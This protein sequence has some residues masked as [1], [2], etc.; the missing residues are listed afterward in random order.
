M[1]K[2]YWRLVFV[3]TAYVYNGF[4]GYDERNGVR[5][6]ALTYAGL[7]FFFPFEQVTI[8]PDWT[9]RELDHDKSTPDGEGE[10]ELVYKTFVVN[11]R[12]VAE[13][14]LMTQVPVRNRDKGLIEIQGKP[15]GRM[16][17][18]TSGSDL[19]GQTLTAEVQEK[20]A[21]KAEREQAAKLSLD[22]K[23]QLIQEYFQSKRERMAGGK[24]RIFPHGI[25]KV[26]MDELQVEDIDDVSRH[27]KV[28]GGLDPATI[29]ALVEAIYKGQ[30]INGARLQE[31][32]ETVRKAGKAQLTRGKGRNTGMAE[33]REAY[34][35]AI[36][37]GKTPEEARELAEAARG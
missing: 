24:G 23:K 21:T 29:T 15:T 37:E 14:L 7:E 35:A 20:E 28:T 5:G 2:W 18:V 27:M 4:G 25:V 10:G 31:A 8:I 12:R 3:S 11:G 32:V 26:F 22:F 16:A 36:E 9:F 19:Y 6:F 17:T 13:E 1:L 33:Y 30:E 34:D